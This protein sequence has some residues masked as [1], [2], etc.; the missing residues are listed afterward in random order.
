MCASTPVPCSHAA[1]EPFFFFF[2]AFHPLTSCEVIQLREVGISPGILELKLFDEK[3][4]WAK[5]MIN[6]RLVG[7]LLCRMLF[8]RLN[9]VDLVP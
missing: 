2:K 4:G 7:Q 6:E 5:D 9:I 1:G 3:S 8:Q